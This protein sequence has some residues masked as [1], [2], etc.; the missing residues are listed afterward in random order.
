MGGLD[1]GSI[2]VGGVTLLER[3]LAATGPARE[4]VVVGNPVRTSRQVT[5]ARENP[6]GGGPA[7]GLLAGLDQF[8]SRPQLVCV[9]A[10]D[11]PLVTA[12]TFGRLLQAVESGPVDGAVLEDAEGHRQPLAAVYRRA[13]LRAARPSDRREEHGLAMKDL[14]S[15]L[16][17]VDVSAQ[18]HEAFDV[19]TWEDVRALSE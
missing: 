17:L 10:V 8:R 5:W 7:A 18:G 3:A 12:R 11:M 19:D 15:G 2:E 6:P 9:L 1:K 14:L 16:R 4:V 13:A